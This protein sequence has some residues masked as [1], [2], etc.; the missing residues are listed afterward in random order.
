MAEGAREASFAFCVNSNEAGDGLE[1]VRSP[2]TKQYLLFL[3]IGMLTIAGWNFFLTSIG[4]YELWFP[5]RQWA[6]ISSMACQGSNL[7]A[8]GLMVAVGG[9]VPFVAGYCGGLMSMIV[10]VIIAPML[11]FWSGSSSWGFW[12]C[13]GLTAVVG[14][15]QAVLTSLVVGVAGALH[16]QLVGAVMAGQGIVGVI[17]PVLMICLKLVSGDPMKYKYEVVF[18]FYGTCAAMMLIGL[19]LVRSIPARSAV[20]TA[21]SVPNR[22]ISSVLFEA[23]PQILNVFGTF[24]LTFLVF[25][26]VAATWKPQVD[27]FTRMG[28]M[29]GDWYTTLIVG[30]FQVFDVV[31]RMSPQVPVRLGISDRLLWIPVL[32]RAVFVP[33]FIS[34]Q[35]L[36]SLLPAPWQSYLELVTMAMFALT[37]GWCATLAMMYGPG[38]VPGE[39]ERVGASMVLALTGGIF[40]GSL[41]ALLTQ[42]GV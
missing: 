36:P 39:E 12:T 28:P 6:F 24:V 22:T 17:A 33:M 2:P 3:Y 25:P 11:A 37:S 7:I 42:L 40:V 31:A 13:I 9:R 4:F 19:F 34:L 14:F 32:S 38:Q 41:L 5:G 27:V 20:T 10:P 26:G 21:S 8:T 30:V 1:V 18:G 16:S 29:G 23:K 35:R 15:G